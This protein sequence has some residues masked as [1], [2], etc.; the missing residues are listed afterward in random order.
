MKISQLPVALAKADTPQG[1]H[2]RR[3]QL[4]VLIECLRE[5]E[6]PRDYKQFAAFADVFR[7][8][9]TEGKRVQ[10]RWSNHVALRH[11]VPSYS[12]PSM[13][14]PTAIFLPLLQADLAAA[15]HRHWKKLIA[16]L[17]SPK[18]A[19]AAREPVPVKAAALFVE[20]R[21]EEDNAA[22]RLRNENTGLAA[23]WQFVEAAKKMEVSAA[24]KPDPK[25][26]Q[27][28][29]Q[30]KLDYTPPTPTICTWSQPKTLAEYV[31]ATRTSRKTIKKF[32]G[33]QKAEPQRR[34]DAATAGRYS[35][36]VNLKILAHWIEF[37]ETKPKDATGLAAATIAHSLVHDR[38]FIQKMLRALVPVL[39]R[40]ALLAVV[41]EEIP[42]N[43][44]FYSASP[45][46]LLG[47]V[48]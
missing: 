27:K 11:E 6:F 34:P 14:C 18:R 4:C 48:N 15:T 21:R 12:N 44:K 30:S 26:R 47:Q 16:G 35:V 3:E 8:E 29:A 40:R 25:A 38:P 45:D 33:A 39:E 42:A 5:A 19:V 28:L 20:A 9:T 31:T 1:K 17:K 23:Y 32:V 37:W 41:L 13:V 43:Y 10:I 36:R 22:A 7:N 24:S 2:Q 46:T